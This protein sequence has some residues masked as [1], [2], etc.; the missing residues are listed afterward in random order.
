MY[1]CICI[2]IIIHI[3]TIVT[4]NYKPVIITKPT[5]T[6]VDQIGLPITLRC[7]VSGDPNHYWVG[8]MHKN[9]MIQRGDGHSH[10]LSTSPS[11][12]SPNST[13]YHLTIHSVKVPGNYTCQVFSIEGKQLD[14][15][16]HEVTVKGMVIYNS[17]V[18]LQCFTDFS[19]F[20][21]STSK[22]SLF[23]TLFSQFFK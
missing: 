6:T 10:S 16:T 3:H 5:T 17:F 1:V 11:L 4:S 8:W 14:H 7:E 18:D 2:A 13:S 19:S 9:S 23:G 15:V 21:E 12:S 22:S 20:I